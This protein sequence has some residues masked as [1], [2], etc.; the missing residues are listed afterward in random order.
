M[1]G[2]VAAML[3]EVDRRGAFHRMTIAR[4]YRESTPGPLIPPSLQPHR[5]ILF[6]ARLCLI[7]RTFFPPKSGG[8]YEGGHSAGDLQPGELHHN[9]AQVPEGGVSRTTLQNKKTKNRKHAVDY[10]SIQRV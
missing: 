2:C 6:H 5:V 10:Y 1:G 8:L 3:F 4:R 7:G 9:G